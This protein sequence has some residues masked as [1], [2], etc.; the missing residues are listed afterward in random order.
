MLDFDA[1]HAF[2][3]QLQSAI[4]DGVQVLDPQAR[5]RTD[6]WER[7]GGG[8]G[9]SAILT[10]GALIEKGGV[11]FSCVEGKAL[12]AAATQRRPNLANRP[13]QATGVS[14]VLHPEN[15][16]VPAAHMNVRFF[17]TTPSQEQDPV[18]WFGGGFD[19]TPTYAFEEDIREWHRHARAACAPFGEHLYAHFKAACDHYFH[20]P[21]RDEMRGVG[22]LFFDDFN[23]LGEAASFALTRSVGESFFPAWKRLAER[24]RNN[25]YTEAH[26]RFQHLRRGRYAEFNLLYDRGTLFG[27]QSGGRT[28]SIL[29]SLPPRVEWEYA[30]E[31][32]PGSPEA[33]LLECLQPKDWLK[34]A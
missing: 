19:L 30:W 7:P 21:H 20:L 34:E 9:L 16:F 2:M 18:W 25:P 29:M 10:G 15:P 24:R 23:E 3:R 17:T 11:N 26:K 13:F 28:E 12:P 33:H 5:L 1:I 14:V 27:L 32:E 8:G 22:G 6:E 31:P 4:L